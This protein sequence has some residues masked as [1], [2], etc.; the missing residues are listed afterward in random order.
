MA[1]PLSA[2]TE[3]VYRVIKKRFVKG[4]VLPY[5]LI[6][7][8]VGV[9]GETARQHALKLQK[10]RLVSIRAGHVVGVK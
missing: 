9:H 3:K 7:D 2:T 4:Q 1:K 10:K 5:A 6:G 8:E